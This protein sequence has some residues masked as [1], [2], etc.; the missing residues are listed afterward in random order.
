MSHSGLLII[1]VFYEI[2]EDWAAP[3][4]KYFSHEPKDLAD[5]SVFEKKITSVYG[6]KIDLSLCVL[7]GKGWCFYSENQFI[8]ADISLSL[9]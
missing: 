2:V 3:S 6:S 4:N 8:K 7:N 9:I 1:T 5:K